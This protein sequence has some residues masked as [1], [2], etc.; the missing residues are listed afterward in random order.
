MAARSPYK[1]A[2]PEARDNVT[3]A[4][5]GQRRAVGDDAKPRGD[6]VEGAAVERLPHQA[7]VTPIQQ[8]TKDQWQRGD[9][10]R[11]RSRRSAIGHELGGRRRSVAGRLRPPR[12]RIGWRLADRDAGR[13]AAQGTVWPAFEERTFDRVSRVFPLRAEGH[14]DGEYTV[15]LNNAGDVLPADDARRSHLRAGDVRRDPEWQR[16]GG[17]LTCPRT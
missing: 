12:T 6:P 9:I 2:W 1:L 15:R 3:L 13:A 8:K 11:V 14:L 7:H 16:T 17:A 5:D 4:Q 10:A